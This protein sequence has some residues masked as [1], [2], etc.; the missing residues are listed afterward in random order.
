MLQ[1]SRYSITFCWRSKSSRELLIIYLVY[2]VLGFFFYNSKVIYYLSL[3][4][5]QNYIRQYAVNC[6]GVDC[7]YMRVET[8]PRPLYDGWGTGIENPFFFFFFLVYSLFTCS[9]PLNL[10]PVKSFNV[11][12][13]LAFWQGT[14]AIVYFPI[15]S[16]P[17]GWIWLEFQVKY[18]LSIIP[19][20]K[21]PFSWKKF[22]QPIFF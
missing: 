4:K 8:A 22:F 16:W 14:T 21:K 3:L 17:R 19:V 5:V 15:A 13:R 11:C 1:S 20:K 9:S 18:F 7:S 6:F 2:L 12:V 10:F